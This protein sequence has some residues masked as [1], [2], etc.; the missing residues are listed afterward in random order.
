MCICVG[1]PLPTVKWPLLKNYTEYSVITT[2]SKD[3]VNSTLVLAAKEHGSVAVQCASANQN[4]KKRKMLTVSR[5]EGDARS[6][7]NISKSVNFMAFEYQF[8]VGTLI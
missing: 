7:Q 2:V 3:T 6:E 4:G 8:S 1:S 5:N